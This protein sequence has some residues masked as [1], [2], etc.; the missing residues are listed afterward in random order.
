MS[1][2]STLAVTRQ[3]APDCTVVALQLAGNEQGPSAECTVNCGHHR[4]RTCLHAQS[5]WPC[6][7]VQQ[8]VA[9]RGLRLICIAEQMFRLSPP[10]HAAL[11][12]SV[13]CHGHCTPKELCNTMKCHDQPIGLVNICLP[14]SERPVGPAMQ[15]ALPS[16]ADF[17]HLQRSKLLRVACVVMPPLQAR[18]AFFGVRHSPMVARMMQVCPPIVRRVSCGLCL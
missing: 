3:P 13:N 17:E 1:L 4:T 14:L 11:R 7:S 6:M 15:M 2:S 9:L 12:E 8:H 18:I 5:P 10:G 16:R